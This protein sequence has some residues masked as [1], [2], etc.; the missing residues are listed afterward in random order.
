NNVLTVPILERSAG[1]GPVLFPGDLTDRGSP[2][3]VRIVRRVVRSG[4]PFVF[5]SGNH[6]SNTV[7][8][9]LADAGAIVLS[10]LGRLNPD[11]S[12]GAVVQRVAG[13]RVAGYSDPFARRS[14]E[15]YADRFQPTPTAAQQDAFTSWMR[16]IQ[17]QV[18][19]IMV[20]EPKLIEPALLVLHDQPPS[21]P[22]LFVTGH[23]HKPDLT[24][25]P[26]VTVVNGGSIG[27]GGT[28]NLAEVK[29]TDVGIA[30]VTYRTDPGFRPLAVDL[31]SI[32]PGSGSA[33]AR[34][35]RL[36]E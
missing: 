8:A 28:G 9:E 4:H 24:T 13:L 19:V 27:G 31:V 36:D 12:R 18:D 3:E 16:S 21:H 15:N 32:D 5:V 35:E 23:T 2:L 10:E 17:D 14:A 11:G 30:R 22:L 25:Q 6:D 20:H 26:G 34:R 1:G 7:E 33:T 29:T